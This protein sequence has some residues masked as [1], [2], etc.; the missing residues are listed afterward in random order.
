[1]GDLADRVAKVHERIS[2]ACRRVGRRPEDVKLIAISKTVPPERIRQAYEAGLRDFGENRVQEA[3]AKRP[4]LS[5]LAVTWHLVGHLQT[6]KAKPARDLFHWIH[7]VDSQRLA[8]KLDKVGAR[9]GDRLPVLLEVNLGEEAAKSGARQDEVPRLA[10]ALSRLETLE[11]RGLMVMPPFFDDAE[12]TR[13][14]F[15]RL[16]E[17]A[18]DVA[19]K[20]LPGVSMQELSMG[21]SHDFEVAIEEGATMV[22]VGTAIFGPR[23]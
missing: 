18:G 7:S 22:R 21:M 13:P 11:V 1:M 19:A 15:R 6:N 2:A 8:E 5:D 3:E 10:E 20:N 23:S 12:R 17:L 14:Y 4:A 9:P 16:R